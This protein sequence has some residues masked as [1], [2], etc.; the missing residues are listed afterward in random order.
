MIEPGH[1]PDD[2]AV[3]VERES[4][5][6]PPGSAVRN[7]SR[8]T[9]LAS[10]LETADGLWG[11]FLGLMGRPD[12]PAG[13]GLWLPESNG[14]HMMFM[15]FPIDVIFLGRPGPEGARSVVGL[16]RALRPWWGVIW[17]VR[18]AHGV[19]EL[20]VGA[21]DDSGTRLGDMVRLEEID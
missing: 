16:R 4:R 17:Y 11:K 10:E 15:R 18:G 2:T 5:P 13:A 20:P 6:G 14:I 12:L 1:A 19:V 3:H 21:I 8:G 7:L 9:V